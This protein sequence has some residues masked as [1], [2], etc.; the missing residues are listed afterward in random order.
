MKTMRKLFVHIA[1]TAF[2]GVLGTQAQAL[3]VPTRADLTAS[4]ASGRYSGVGSFGGFLPSGVAAHSCT[5]SLV[6]SNVIL[7]AAHCTGTVPGA[8]D[9]AI[10]FFLPAAG[11][12]RI[13]GGDFYGLKNAFV[14]PSYRGFGLSDMALVTLTSE[15]IGHTI[16]DIYTDRDELGQE[17]TMV[18]AGLSGAMNEGASVAASDNRLRMGKNR[19]D[20][21]GT[22]WGQGEEYGDD[23]LGMDNDNG[24]PE[25]DVYGRFLGKPDLGV[26]ENGR[27]VE[28]GLIYGDSGGPDFIGNKIAGIHSVG[29]SGMFF[30]PVAQGPTGCGRPGSVDVAAAGSLP[31]CSD[32]SFGDFGGSVRTSFYADTIRSY[33]AAAAVPEPSTWLMMLAG[34]GMV[35]MVLRR[36]PVAATA[37][38]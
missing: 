25:N 12:Y 15:A 21:T 29:G 23:I 38:A 20:V 6:S 18:G 24:R 27:L 17:I 9:P 33:I 10:G 22:M 19:Y 35:G 4:L 37:T 32:G 1:T 8:F 26:F 7:T 34:F 3:T 31:D 2:A 30:D 36:R 28:S 5:A 16:Y 11:D 14:I 13:G